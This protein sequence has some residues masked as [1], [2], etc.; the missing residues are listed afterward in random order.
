MD[1]QI[2]RATIA[3]TGMADAPHPTTTLT[4][5]RY[6][7][8]RAK[9]WAFGMMQFAHAPLRHCP[10]LTFYK[11]LGSGKGSGFNPLPDWSVY[12]L[13][14]VWADEAQ[15]RDF[16][17]HADLMR[18]YRAHAAE[19]W[20]LYL[21]VLTA[22]GEWSGRNPFP[23]PAP[24]DPTEPRIAVITRATIRPGHLVRFWQYVPTSQKPLRDH[25]GLLYTKGIGE[26]PI[27]QM[28]T[29]SLW[30]N[31][32]ALRAFAYQSAEHREAIART[33]RFDWYAE[34]LFARFQPYRSEGEWSQS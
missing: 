12:A 27:V 11:L 8:L 26:V 4:F 19:V 32:E 10:G 9:L 17:Q 14:Q 6:R 34:E 30:Q 28:A 15:A 13:L 16:F 7:G 21:R 25:A 5:F 18:R 1:G 23:P 24:P 2:G 33:R 31:A 20:T 3:A 29:F 22:K